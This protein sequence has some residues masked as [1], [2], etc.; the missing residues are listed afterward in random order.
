MLRLLIRRA[1]L[2]SWPRRAVFSEMYS[3]IVRSSARLTA[4][5]R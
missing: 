1:G 3:W 5:A 4:P 2:A